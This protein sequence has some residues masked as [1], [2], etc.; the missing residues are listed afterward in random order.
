MSVV[1]KVVTAHIGDG[2]RQAQKGGHGEKNSRPRAK[3]DLPDAPCDLEAACPECYFGKGSQVALVG[4]AKPVQGAQKISGHFDENADEEQ[5]AERRD[6][7]R[8]GIVVLFQERIDQSHRDQHGAD[9]PG[10]TDKGFLRDAG[11]LQKEKRRER[12]EDTAKIVV[13]DQHDNRDVGE[14]ERIA[15]IDRAHL[16]KQKRAGLFPYGY[17]TFLARGDLPIDRGGHQIAGN[18][19]EELDAQVPQPEKIDIP[20]PDRKESG[21]GEMKIESG[22]VKEDN[23]GRKYKAKKF[24]DGIF[25]IHRFSFPVPDLS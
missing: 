8:E 21:I 4:E 9:I 15:G 6:Q 3:T 14:G 7:R 25:V 10:Q 24:D 23:A 18:H 11:S 13:T 20:R 17:L 2:C 16:F 5:A 22:H 19:E 1:I 12:S